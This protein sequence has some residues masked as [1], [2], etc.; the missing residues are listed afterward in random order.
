MILEKRVDAFA[1]LGDIMIQATEGKSSVLSDGL[2]RLINES[3]RTNPWFT[4]ENV[5]LALEALGAELNSVQ[6]NKWLAQY[7]DLENRTNPRRIAVVM[8]GN[9][10]MVGFHDMMSVL[11]TG[12]NLI[13]KTSS[14][15]DQ[16]IKELAS[17]LIRVEP[18]FASSVTFTD[19]SLKDFDAV[20]ATGS[21]NTSRYFEYYFGRYHSLIRKNRTG[22]GFLSGNE[23]SQQMEALGSDVFSYFGLGCRNVTKIY[24]PDNFDFD[25]LRLSWSRFNKILHNTKYLNNYE[26]NKAVAIINREKFNDFGFVL[27]KED[28]ALFSPVGV[29][30][31]E[32]ISAE[33]FEDIV[34]LNEDKIQVI[35]SEGKHTS[36]GS[37]QKPRLWD[38]SDGIDTIEF[39]LKIN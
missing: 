20:I 23:T 37:A 9:I 35:V 19:E 12:N 1:R 39:L 6:L 8:A 30:N 22:I 24:L 25:K 14:K 18:G 2:I 31:Y 36:F 5:Q 4:R 17:I 7:P 28:M 26:H 29:V 13:A 21:D 33:R 11:I 3:H 15:D 27:L 38:Y 32:F 34:K 16:I 10:P